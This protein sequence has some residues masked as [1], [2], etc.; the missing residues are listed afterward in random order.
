MQH[1]NMLCIFVSFIEAN[2]V[3]YLVKLHHD[4]PLNIF[5][6]LL[7]HREMAR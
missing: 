5:H 6:R 7:A 4:S 3:V 2:R 1:T